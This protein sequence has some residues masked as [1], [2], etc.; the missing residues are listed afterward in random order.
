M[1]RVQAGSTTVEAYLIWHSRRKRI[2]VGLER[3][4]A[5]FR[6]VALAHRLWH[7]ASDGVSSVRFGHPNGWTWAKAE[8]T[9]AV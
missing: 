5:A 3:S 6:I 9:N 8:A 1:I 7:T 2:V 4:M